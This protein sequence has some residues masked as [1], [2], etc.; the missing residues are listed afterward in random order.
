MKQ[1]QKRSTPTASHKQ[2]KQDPADPPVFL[3]DVIGSGEM[4]HRIVKVG[5]W[6]LTLPG[7]DGAEP[8][9]PDDVLAA[10]LRLRI[11]DL[12]AL[13]KRHAAA[14]NIKPI[15]VLRTVR[16]TGGRPSSAMLFREADALFLASRSETPEAVAI[17]KEM[18]LVYMLAHRH[19]LPDQC[20]SI[21][22][23]QALD[24]QTRTLAEVAVGSR[25]LA[26]SMIQH[27]QILATI[28]ETNKA[29]AAGMAS[30][31]AVSQQILLLIQTMQ[32]MTQQ[33]TPAGAVRLDDLNKALASMASH[34]QR[35][36]AREVDD[37]LLSMG[38][39]QRMRGMIRDI[40]EIKASHLRPSFTKPRNPSESEKEAWRQYE[41]ARRSIR[42]YL[43]RTVRGYANYT[44]RGQSLENYPVGEPY[45]KAFLFLSQ[46][47]EKAKADG[48]K[49]RAEAPTSIRQ[50]E[51]FDHSGQPKIK[52]A[53]N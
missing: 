2:G 46:E 6:E 9:M 3:S 16:E 15:D 22:L 32:Q 5:D 52:P 4:A 44:A 29:I 19:L 38:E 47:L 31:H 41:A 51:L 45:T 28:A 37:V 34:V 1:S 25:N 8:L 10:R 26:A 50:G 12:R 36:P 17:T 23:K 40:I 13:A 33:I 11:Q 43:H 18:I 48:A 35:A 20:Q 39:V 24:Q 21:E 49:H 42:L 14:G 30:Q 53:A 27:G 7:V